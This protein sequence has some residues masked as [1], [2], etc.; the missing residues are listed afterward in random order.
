MHPRYHVLFLVLS[1]AACAT[2]P[3]EED[4]STVDQAVT[5]GTAI[6]TW[7]GTTSFA[8]GGKCQNVFAKSLT[9]AGFTQTSGSV[10][11]DTCG[12]Q[13]VELALRYFHFRKGIPATSW[14]I[15]TAI[16][17]CNAR[18]AGVS[19]TSSPVAGD[20][21]VLKANDS[22]VQTGPEGHVA[23]VRSLSG[24]SVATFNENWANDSTAF[25][26]ISRSRDVAC[27][28][29]AGGG[30]GGPPSQPK[31]TSQE[32]V[33]ATF[34]GHHFWTCQGANRYVCDDHGNK[35]TQAC[36]GGCVVMAVGTDDQCGSP[37]GARCSS[38]EQV[39]ATFSG[40]HFWTCQ[41]SSRYIC[42]DHS[43]KVAQ[44]CAGGC[45][46]MG[47]GNDDQCN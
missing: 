30:G 32:I 2:E 29:H 34:S 16:Q 37:T 17:M 25:A 4:T 15:G 5:A 7:D 42:D 31:C 22:A 10:L 6:G 47:V 45:V 14:N 21:V 33:N 40:A 9:S 19:L 18:P 39:N 46:G 26:T 38:A 1:I 23:I 43:N 3:F 44:S 8:F 41:S 13:C 28:L 11:T 27:F 35:I 36:S 20:L 12:F 24:D